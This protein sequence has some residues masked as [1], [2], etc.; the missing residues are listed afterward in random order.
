MKIVA[1][2]SSARDPARLHYLTTFLVDGEVAI[3]AG[4][5]GLHATPAEQAR[6]RDVFLTHSH[7]DHT[8]A[9]P[10]FLENVIEEGRDGPDVHGHE[11]TLASLEGD[12]FND[13]VWPD[14]VAVRL[15]ERRLLRLH[16]LEREVAVTARGLSLTPVEVSHAVPTFGYLVE[17]ESGSVAFSGDT[18]PTSRLW[19]LARSRRN[20][21]AVF[22]ELSFPDERAELAQRAGHLTPASFAREI[23]KLGRR[24][25]AVFAFHLKPRWRERILEQLAA[26]KLGGVEVAELGRE[27]RI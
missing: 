16:R 6:V 14:F 12:V 7:A 13:R 4:C 21:R 17:D 19:E 25:V 24:D 8:A 2:P 20:L 18:G 5:L 23:G 26:L 11:H 9:L 15:G 10:M 27:Y 3:D 22:L 1:L